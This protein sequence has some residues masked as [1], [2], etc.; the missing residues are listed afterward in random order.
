MVL[1]DAYTL[2]KML[3]NVCCSAPHSCLVDFLLTGLLYSTNL[4]VGP[5]AKF[6][7]SLDRMKADDRQAKSKSTYKLERASKTNE[8]IP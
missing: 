6:L 2:E 5:S 7:I 8:D 4:M 1:S 3:Y